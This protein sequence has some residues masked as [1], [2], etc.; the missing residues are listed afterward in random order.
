MNVK[1][2]PGKYRALLA[3]LVLA[4]GT[5]LLA[6]PANAEAYD[7][8]NGTINCTSGNFLIT[9]NI[10]VS[11]NECSGAAFITE[12][13]TSIG[14]AAFFGATALRSITIP[15]SVTSIGEAA[16]NT[17]WGL[18]S[19]N[20]NAANPNYSSTAGVLFSKDFTTLVT[21]PPGKVETSYTIASNVT[22]I[23]KS[24][25]SSASALRSITIPSSVTSIGQY[26]F[27]LDSLSQLTSINVNAANPNYSSTAGV[28]FNKGSTTLLMYP[29]GKIETSYTIPASVT[30]LGELAFGAAC[31]LRSITIPASVRSIAA[32]GFCL[33]YSFIFLGDAPNDI[34]E[35]AFENLP[36]TATA[37]IN[38]GATGFGRRPAQWKG[39]F[40]KNGILTVTYN[41]NGGS[42][43]AAHAFGRTIY[44]PTSP[45]RAG[46]TFAGWSLTNG[47]SLISF[48]HT[49]VDSRD[50][51]LYAK[52]T[53]NV[54]ASASV[55]PKIAGTVKVSKTLTVNKGTWRGAPTPEY[56][57]QWYSCSAQVKTATQTIPKNCKAVSKA[58]K[59]TLVVNSAL[60]GKYLAI[61]VTG[62]SAGTT[63]TKWLSKSTTKVN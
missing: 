47:G 48:P 27:P 10:V 18:T 44:T 17:A 63:A 45:T 2:L 33:I 24:A 41:V 22:S 12:G 51:T 26:A 35:Y 59:S 14:Y 21:Y 43:V 13:V 19:I 4:L 52:W 29:R 39:L 54:K 36:N 57:Y 62:K 20:V 15:A 9:G 55:K 49:S 25:F 3:I 61:L 34:N 53:K 37:Y 5:L 28:L 32:G 23:G 50:T 6:A 42:S 38:F 58:T 46:Y 31:N 60:K 7:G 8:D 40:V 1:L 30:S 16:L 56:S 11:Q